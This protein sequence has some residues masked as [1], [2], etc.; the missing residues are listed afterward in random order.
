MGNAHNRLIS[1]TACIG[2]PNIEYKMVQ[3]KRILFANITEVVCALVTLDGLFIPPPP[4]SYTRAI[5]LLMA[6]VFSAILSVTKEKGPD[7]IGW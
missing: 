2:A 4:F 7:T 1:V 5:G 6:I 3:K